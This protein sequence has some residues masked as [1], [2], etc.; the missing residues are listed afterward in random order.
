MPDAPDSANVPQPRRSVLR[1][2]AKSTIGSVFS[3][4]FTA[5][6]T[7]LFAPLLLLARPT[8]AQGFNVTGPQLLAMDLKADGIVLDIAPTPDSGASVPLQAWRRSHC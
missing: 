5:V 2:A 7:P 8:Q 4:A 6:L 3:R 1:L